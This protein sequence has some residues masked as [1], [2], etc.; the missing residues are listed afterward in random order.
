VPV[1][2]S[3]RD[4]ADLPR[5]VGDA[6]CS[7]TRSSHRPAR[8]SGRVVSARTV[9]HITNSIIRSPPL[10]RRRQ[11]GNPSRHGDRCSKVIAMNLILSALLLSTSI[12]TAP[13]GDDVPIPFADYGKTF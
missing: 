9:E 6:R 7:R 12:M 3:L 2:S 11:A 13:T 1:K 8:A 4:V 10:D 5:L